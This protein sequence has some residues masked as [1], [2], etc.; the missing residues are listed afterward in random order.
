MRKS[1]FGVLFITT[2][3]PIV[4]HAQH[5]EHV[6]VRMDSLSNDVETLDR[7]VKQLSKFKVSAYL[8]GQY[9]YGEKDATLK[10]GDTNEN[11]EEGFNRIGI[12]RGRMKF[13]YNDELGTGALQIEANDKGVSFRDLYIGIKDPWTKRNRLMAGVF[14][15]PFGYE[16][17][18]STS[19]LES[20]ERATVIQYFFPDERDLGAMLTLRAPEVS[21]FSFL[22][23]DAGLF[24]GNSIN[25]ETDN[26]KDLIG[27]IGA[28]KQ[29]GNQMQWGLGFSYYNGSVFNPTTNAYEMEGKEFHII[30][31]HKTGTYMKR[32]YFGLDAQYTVFSGLGKTTFRAEGLWGMQPGIATSSKSPN[33]SS[34]PANNETN[35]LYARPFL[36]YFFY[37]IQDIGSSPFSL[38]LKYDAY[39]PNTKVKENEVGREYSLTTSTDLAQSTIGIGVLYRI[40]R[41]IRLQCYYEF[42]QNEKSE[43]IEG[44]STDRKDNVLTVRL[45]Y[46]F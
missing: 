42:N 26:R 17:S 9:Q 28:K 20:P 5:I 14:N 4:I 25:R 29:I 10:V 41:H 3:I 38:V 6:E 16:V 19:N 40:N 34:R 30:E 36:G 31:K 15:R 44:Y 12:R 7:V 43:N 35:A 46:K 22:R 2:L 32:E 27:R 23:L 11:P 18:Y 1:F 45:Q 33:Y 21:P 8:Q 13:E 24:A 39:D 37:L